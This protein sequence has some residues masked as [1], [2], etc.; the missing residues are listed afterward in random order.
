MEKLLNK[1]QQEHLKVLRKLELIFNGIFSTYL[2]LHISVFF[3]LPQ[4][5]LTIFFWWQ[6]PLLTHSIRSVDLSTVDNSFSL[7]VFDL[8]GVPVPGTINMNF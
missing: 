8:F 1:S 5:P 7:L 4:F 2:F 3:L 6:L